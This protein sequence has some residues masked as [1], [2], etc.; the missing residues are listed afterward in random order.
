MLTP[1]LLASALFVQT[2]SMNDTEA[3]NLAHVL[4]VAHEL[5]VV[6]GSCEH[7]LSEETRKETISGID[8]GNPMIDEVFRN[9]LEEGRKSPSA[10]NRTRQSCMIDLLDQSAKFQAMANAITSNN[11]E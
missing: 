3:Q 7:V 9:G 11:P 10:R 5:M 4:K 6:I 8:T 2:P 1:V